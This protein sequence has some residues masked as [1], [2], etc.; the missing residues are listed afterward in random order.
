MHL[1]RSHRHAAAPAIILVSDRV[2]VSET[3]AKRRKP[4]PTGSERT[5]IARPGFTRQ[6][7]L[8]AAGG[9]VALSALGRAAEAQQ[10]R[11][12]IRIGTDVDAQS[13][14]PRL[15]RETTG[16]RVINLVFS[17]L[18]QLDGQLVPQPDLATR[19]ENPDPRTWIFYLRRA[20]K[21]HDGRPVTAADV[22]F[23]VRTIVDPALNAR[24]RSLY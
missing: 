21:F 14:D 8:R 15:Q 17:G 4:M 19:W 13:L 24:F 12:V 6:E 11:S 3:R 1:H 5:G 10:A 23:T 18:V 20:A 9:A 22:V 2:P 16:Y 7:F